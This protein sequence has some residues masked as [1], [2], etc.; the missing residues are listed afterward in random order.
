MPSGRTVLTFA[1]LTVREASRRRLLVAVAILTL[2]VIV[3]TGW[4]FAQLRS[5]TIDHGHPLSQLT[6]TVAAAQMLIVV[7][8]LFAGVLALIAV[9]V[10]AGSISGDIESHLA[11]A[12]LAR[13]VRRSELLLGKWLGMATVLVAYAVVSGTLE[14]VAVDVATGYVPPHPVQLIGYVAALGLNLL[15]LTL[16]LSTRLAGMTAGIIPIVCY[17]MA[18]I[19][20]IVGGVG[21]ALGNNALM[22]AATVTKILLPTDGLWRGAVYAMEP[23]AI[24]ATVRSAGAFAAANPFSA[25]YPP[26]TAFLVW[27]VI[28]FAA[29]LALALWSMRT[30]EI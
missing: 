29:I 5:P 21:Q 1:G 4:G 10:A 9:L 23:A 28:W 6:L 24:I 22:A 20:G 16:L 30:R 27:A 2:I 19:G 14:L 11:L 15:T 8:F 17:F 25:A 7:A 12:L 13:P 26:A 18:W 3:G